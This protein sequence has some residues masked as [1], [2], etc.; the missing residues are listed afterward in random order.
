MATLHVPA[1]VLIF[2]MSVA[3]LSV[4]ISHGLFMANDGYEY[5]LA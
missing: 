3:I 2:A 5:A 1:A 4:H